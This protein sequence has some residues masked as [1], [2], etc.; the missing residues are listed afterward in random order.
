M[1]GRW[2]QMA[3]AAGVTTGSD[4]PGAWRPWRWLQMAAVVGPLVLYIWTASPGPYW[5]DSSELV[6]AAQVGGVPHPP[7]HPL[8]AA[9]TQWALLVPWG[10]VA[11]RVNLVSAVCGAAASGVL[12]SLVRRWGLRQDLS[13]ALAGGIAL[14]AA[15]LSAVTYAVWFQAVRAEVYTLHLLVAA[16]AVHLA[17]QM[18]WQAADGAPLDV[19]LLYGLGLCAGLG[20][21]NH[22]YLMLF[23]L[24]P[25]G[26]MAL[27]RSGWRRALLSWHGARAVGFGL[28]GLALYGLL[29]LAAWRDPLVNWGDPGGLD[30]L[31]WVVSAQA[32]QGSLGRAADV[33]AGTLAADLFGQVARQLTPV[34]LVLA[35]V[36]WVG[37]W[38]GARGTA[39]LWGGF[40][41]L[42]LIT[43]SL[44]NFDPFNPDVH[45]YFAL[46]AWML[47]LLVGCG[48]ASFVAAT[49]TMEPDRPWVGR[50]AGGVGLAVV[51]A[52]LPASMVMT[53]R[54]ADRAHFRDVEIVTHAMLDELPEGSVV[55]TSNY[56]TLFD[57]WYAQGV[58]QRRPDVVTVHRNFFPNAPYIDELRRNHPELL[59]LPEGGGGS[60]RVDRGALLALA[61]ERPVFIE[62]DVN[63]QDDLLPWLVPDGLLFRVSPTAVPPGPFPVEIGMREVRRWLELERRLVARAGEAPLDLET[64]RHLVWVH[65]L[66]ALAMARAGHE[67]V[68]AF[69][70]E[71]AVAANPSAP[72]LIDLQRQLLEL[73]RSHGET[74]P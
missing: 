4:G 64:Q 53:W 20:G 21:A 52:L 19:R 14:I 2:L 10:S 62:Y 36:G 51:A 66:C 32:F 69:H 65:Y 70:L 44:M 60:T 16:V 46:T 34:G 22:H 26:V 9:V 27:V 24:A 41:A 31:W 73:R 11:L 63:V 29:V 39:A 59:T 47:A 43:Q 3:A 58:E 74:I 72:E 18:E 56:K 61:A 45:G 33:Q 54:D 35:L 48:L 13:Q 1:S 67:D 30:G 23:A 12:A 40:V 57:V 38:R 50:I 55:L 7:G 68:A 71:R 42:N 5:L 15:W 37:A 17:T 8:Y 6:A 49:R 25:I 28:F